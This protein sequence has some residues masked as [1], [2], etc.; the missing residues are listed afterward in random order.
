[1]KRAWT[2]FALTMVFLTWIS[3]ACAEGLSRDQLFYP[4]GI[5]ADMRRGDILP[6]ADVMPSAHMVTVDRVYEPTSHWNHGENDRH[7]HLEGEPANPYLLHADWC[8]SRQ[9]KLGAGYNFDG[10][11]DELAEF[12]YD[13][14]GLFIYVIGKM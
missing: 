11:S 3:S 4:C 7:A 8:L 12:E 5:S 14:E 6:E 1:M 10:L 2:Y 13:N 9:V